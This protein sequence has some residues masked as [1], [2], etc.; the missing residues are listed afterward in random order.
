MVGLCDSTFLKEATEM[1]IAEPQSVGDAMWNLN[2]KAVTDNC[3]S[4]KLV[5]PLYLDGKEFVTPFCCYGNDVDCDLCGG[6]VVFNLAARF[7]ESDPSRLKDTFLP[8]S[9]ATR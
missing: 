2:A 6:W 8:N 7:E 5:L 9:A 1:A 3:L 4:R